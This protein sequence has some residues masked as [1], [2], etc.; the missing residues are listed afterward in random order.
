VTLANSDREAVDEQVV[1]AQH[2]HERVPDELPRGT[3]G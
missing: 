2:L 3:G 1:Q